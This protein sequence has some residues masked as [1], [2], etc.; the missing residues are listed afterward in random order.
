MI[1]TVPPPADQALD[2]E[3]A[4]TDL[5]AALARAEAA[6]VRGREVTPY[7][8]SQVA[9]LSGGRSLAANRALLV[10]NARVA[11]DAAV[12]LATSSPDS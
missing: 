7:L 8:L 2:A 10:N 1:L 3:R 12:A 6:G 9:E 4:Q 5:E 11:A